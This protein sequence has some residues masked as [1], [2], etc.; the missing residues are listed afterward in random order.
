MQ[1]SYDAVIIRWFLCLMEIKKGFD[2]NDG[3]DGL[4]SEG[5]VG[6]VEHVTQYTYG[7]RDLFHHDV[8]KAMEGPV[9]KFF[10]GRLFGN[11]MLPNIWQ[12][13][14]EDSQLQVSQLSELKPYISYFAATAINDNH[15]IQTMGPLKMGK[16]V[17]TKWTSLK[18]IYNQIEIYH[19]V[20]GF[21]WDNVWGAGIEGTAAGSVWDT[22]VDPKS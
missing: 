13:L 19:S 5:D 22:Y 20:S 14:C 21:H 18:K 4:L 6:E 3:I 12:M 8:R 1:S 17:K 2:L 15:T 10:P 16:M 7:G 9:A 11:Q